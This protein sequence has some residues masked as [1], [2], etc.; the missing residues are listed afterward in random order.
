M[1][2]EKFQVE[3]F[4]R[5]SIRLKEYDYA[6]PGWYFVTICTHKMIQSLGNVKNGKVVLTNAGKIADEEWKKTKSVRSN[7]DLDNYVIMPNHIHGIIIIDHSVGA[8]RRIAP[9]NT[10]ANQRFAPTLKP[11]SLGSIIGQFKSIVTKRVRKTGIPDFRWQRNYYERIIRN[12][13]EL[14]QIRKYLQL[15]P[16]KWEIEKET[17]ENLEFI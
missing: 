1:L 12:E 14:Y 15:N 7:V 8:I 5:H 17:P 6:Q 11:N 2:S 3:S 9:N 10:E 16:L 13:K 4:G